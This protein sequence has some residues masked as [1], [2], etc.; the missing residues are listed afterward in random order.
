M[1]GLTGKLRKLWESSQGISWSDPYIPLAEV[2]NNVRGELWVIGENAGH[3]KQGL[4]R[5]KDESLG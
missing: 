5:L 2:G 3:L 4:A 1:G